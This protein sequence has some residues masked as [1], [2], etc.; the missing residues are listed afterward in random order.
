MVRVLRKSGAC[1]E[2]RVVRVLRKSGACTEGRVVRVL[3]EEWCVYSG[4]FISPS[5][6]AKKPGPLKIIQYSMHPILLS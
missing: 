2:G 1:T 3:R 4:Q 6:T 5:T